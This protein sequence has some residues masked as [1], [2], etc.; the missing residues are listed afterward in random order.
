MRIIRT[1]NKSQTKKTL[2]VFLDVDGVL[3]KKSDW[4][5]KF[6]I[7][8]D[9]VQVLSDL[10]ESI[11]NQWIPYVILC[12]TWRA[13]AGVNNEAPQY[14]ALKES[15]I[16]YGIRIYDTTPLS[17][18]G[19]QAEIEYYIRRNNVDDYIVI[20]DDPSLFEFPDRIKL[21]TPDYKTGLIDSD[22][23]KIVKLIG[24]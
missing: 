12:S 24:G 19:R 21:Y 1:K 6:Y 7:R 14:T 8:D 16:Q 22:I 11:N 15:L 9:C 2:Y 5:N 18:K 13:G 3:N 4:V 17:N 20:D 10:F 23:K